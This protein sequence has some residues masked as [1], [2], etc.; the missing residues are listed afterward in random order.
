MN[1]LTPKS[2]KKLRLGFIISLTVVML[3]LLFRVFF[4][5][6]KKAIYKSFNTQKTT[7]TP[8]TP[9]EVPQELSEKP[10]LLPSKD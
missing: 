7:P 6:D 4:E 8:Q 5:E 2:L 10:F 3:F 1:T 9:Q